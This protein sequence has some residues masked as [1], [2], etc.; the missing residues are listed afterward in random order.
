MSATGR[1]WIR[2]GSTFLIVAF[3]LTVT[4]IGFQR[5]RRTGN[6]VDSVD[7]EEVGI[8]PR[9]M[10]IGLY[11]G[12]RHTETLMG[13]TVFIL[14]SLRTLSLASGWQ[15]IEGVRLQLFRDGEPGPILTAESAS[16]NINTRDARLEGGI[17][18]EF[19]NGA[20]LITEAGRFQ[21]RQ[22]VFVSEA[23]VLYVDGPT[24]GQAERASYSLDEDWIKLEGNAALRAEDG[25]MLV[26]PKLMYRRKERRVFLS[27]GV[28]LTQGLSRL[29][30]PKANVV[31]ATSDGAPEKIELMGGVDVHT[32]VESTGALVKMWAETVVSRRDAHGQWQVKARTTG[33]WVEV[34]FT[35][36]PD[37][38]ERT[39]RTM[40]LSAVIGPHG[41]ISMQT[42]NGVCLDEVPMEGPRRSASAHTARAWFNNGQLTDVELDGQ[43]EIKAGE[44]V[45][46]GQRVRLVQSSGLVMF[47]G[48]PTGRNRV[49]LDSARGRMSCDQA[50]LFDREGR[51]EA[52]GQVHGELRN[53]RLLGSDTSTGDDEP[54]RFAGEILE[55]GEDG[56]MYSLRNNARVWLGHHLLLADDLVY[57]HDTETL[58]ARGHVRATFPANQMDATAAEEDDVAVVARSLDY[59][60]L[61]GLAVFRGSVYYS[62]PKHSLSANKL[63]I[64]FDENDEISDIE[65]EGAVEIKDLEMGRRLTG[66]YARREVESEVITVTGSPAQLIDERG[67]VASGESL[68]WDQADGTVS[69]DGGTELIYYPEEQP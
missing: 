36:G 42:E 32:I 19:P 18:V 52:R 65:A 20:F 8:D 4:M 62:D 27:D 12:F 35:G 55:V 15:E 49:V 2:Y 40:T 17:H 43:V 34:R 39:L 58:N 68:T 41:I 38:Y 48:D 33:P 66:Q 29:T 11:R 51:I 50:T 31:L 64:A 21:S 28:E 61:V 5:T 9:D 67:N 16:F 46:R 7:P 13:Q 22:Q 26:A 59:D 56:D 37:Y 25:A 54:V 14:N 63:S 30:A 53:A 3:L 57:R 10:A 24:F 6:G 44:I 1:A 45:G 60:A 47:Q 69:I 23:P